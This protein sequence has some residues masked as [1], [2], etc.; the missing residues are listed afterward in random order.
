MASLSCRLRPVSSSANGMARRRYRGPVSIP[1]SIPMMVTPLS[2]SPAS[3]ARAMGAAPRQRGSREAC[4]LIQPNRGSVS[5]G[6][7]SRWP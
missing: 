7:G 6:G 5:S 1:A 4:T 3:I 2:R